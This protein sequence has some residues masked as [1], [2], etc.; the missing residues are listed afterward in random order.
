M[1]FPVFGIDNDF[2]DLTSKTQVTTT[3][4]KLDFIQMENLCT[5]KDIITKV[6][7]AGT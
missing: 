6:Y 3:K 4:S 2:L 1:N 5:M 7:G